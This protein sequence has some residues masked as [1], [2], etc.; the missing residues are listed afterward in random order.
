MGLIQQLPFGASQDEWDSWMSAL[1]TWAQN[2]DDITTGLPVTKQGVTN[3]MEMSGSTS[4]A[5][6]LY[7]VSS[8]PAQPSFT[9][10]VVY[11]GEDGRV[12]AW[13]NTLNQWLPTGATAFD[14]LTGFLQAGQILIGNQLNICTNG[15]CT[16]DAVGSTPSGWSTNSSYSNS[17]VLCV[18]G[19]STPA[20]CP[21]NNCLYIQG[22]DTNFVAGGGFDVKPNEVYYLE[23]Y[24]G[25]DGTTPGMNIGLYFPAVRSNGPQWTA[26]CG[27]P[28]GQSG[29]ITQNGTITVPTWAN[30]AQVWLQVNASGSQASQYGNNWFTGIECVKS[31]ATAITTRFQNGG[32]SNTNTPVTVATGSFFTGNFSLLMLNLIVFT[33]TTSITGYVDILVDGSNVLHSVFSM[34]GPF[35]T[36]TTVNPVV[37]VTAPGSHTFTINVTN[38]STSANSIV[39]SSGSSITVL[40]MLK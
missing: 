35:E 33:T 12:Y 13:H 17:P 19:S 14:Q 16:N 22:R 8:L 6:L 3:I 24:M 31:P 39:V 25:S 21:T 15:C 26:A 9:N 37:V 29:W 11:N 7:Y 1:V 10:Q 32:I 34:T 30:R 28:P 23:G 5:F 36:E 27:A 20:G 2:Q 18:A 40:N 4:N 38:S